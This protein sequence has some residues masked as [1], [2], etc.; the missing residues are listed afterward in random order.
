MHNLWEIEIQMFQSEDPTRRRT[1][2]YML[3]SDD[4]NS[5]IK[6]GKAEDNEIIAPEDDGEVSR[7]H[8]KVCFIPNPTIP[9]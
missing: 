9:N 8:C 4:N 2:S 3:D 6:I 7:R 5:E 1:F